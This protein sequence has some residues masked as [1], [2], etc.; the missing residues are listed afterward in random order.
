MKAI[1]CSAGIGSRLGMD[2]PKALVH[3][4]G[5]CL[6]EWQ[7]E[8]LSNYDITV[9]IGYKKEELIKILDKHSI[10][11]VINDNFES[12]NTS[13]SISLC[14]YDENC[15]IIDGDLIFNKLDIKENEEFIGI[16]DTRS[17]QPVC[18]DISYDNVVA[19]H[20]SK[21][22][23]EWACIGCFNP[24]LFKG[25]T[26][27]YVYSVLEKRLPIK[28]KIIESY[29]IDTKEDLAGVNEWMATHIKQFTNS[30]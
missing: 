17:S 1:I 12:T 30:G 8:A 3:V 14:N 23:Y 16:C 7:L 27:E 25:C 2:I 18:V 29:E 24:M 28:Y 5:K 10:N 11:Y 6:L 19:F 26:T 13:C 9:V 21:T 20:R 4:N 15:L 22:Q